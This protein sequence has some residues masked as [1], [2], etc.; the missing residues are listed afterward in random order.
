MLSAISLFG[1]NLSWDANSTLAAFTAVLVVLIILE[2][3][4][5]VAIILWKRK[6]SEQAVAD[7]TATDDANAEQTDAEGATEDAQGAE[8]PDAAAEAQLSEA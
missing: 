1:K 3:V 2:V 7:T 8:A 6:G 5:F 4:A